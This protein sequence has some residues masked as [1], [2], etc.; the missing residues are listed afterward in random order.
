MIPES[1]HYPGGAAVARN[2][3]SSRAQGD[4]LIMIDADELIKSDFISQVVEVIRN[5][6]VDFVYVLAEEYI[7]SEDEIISPEQKP[8]WSTGKISP[9]SLRD[10]FYHR[11]VHFPA[12]PVTIRADVFWDVGGYSAL[13]SNE[14]TNLLVKIDDDYQGYLISQPLYTYRRWDKQHTTEQVFLNEELAE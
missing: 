3:A 8:G 13:I 1:H 12:A 10:A 9:G 6:N 11:T 4:I 7:V 5:E 14:D 2:L